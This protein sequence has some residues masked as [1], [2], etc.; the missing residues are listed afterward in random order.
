MMISEAMPQEPIGNSNRKKRLRRNAK[1][2][3]I[4]WI[5]GAVRFHEETL[6]V[7]LGPMDKDKIDVKTLM[8]P[9]PHPAQHPYDDNYAGCTCSATYTLGRKK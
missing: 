5:D 7:F 6:T 8:K 1:R 9:C 3:S 4:R 2:R